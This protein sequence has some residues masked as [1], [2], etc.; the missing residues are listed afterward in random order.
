MDSPKP[1]EMEL[2]MQSSYADGRWNVTLQAWV[3]TQEAANKLIRAIEIMKDFLPEGA[4][5]IAGRPE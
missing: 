3:S 5:H 2:S 1:K 4:P